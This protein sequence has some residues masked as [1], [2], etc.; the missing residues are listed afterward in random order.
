MSVGPKKQPKPVSGAIDAAIHSLGLGPTYNGWMVVQKWP[1][2][3]GEQIAR[4]ANAFRY[5]DGVLYVAVVD[6]AWRQN[7]AMELEQIIRHIRSYPYGRV[8]KEIRLVA[9]ERG[10]Q[11]K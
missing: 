4:R 2:L 3:V 11:A 6:A 9:S 10:I 1:E 7:L 5:A 8:I